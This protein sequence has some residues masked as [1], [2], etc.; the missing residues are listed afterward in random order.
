MFHQAVLDAEPHI[1]LG[2]AQG[3]VPTVTHPWH[4]RLAPLAKKSR[5]L[6]TLFDITLNVNF[7]TYL[8]AVISLLLNPLHTLL[9]IIEMI[10]SLPLGSIL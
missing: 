5:A 8:S 1:P 2:P 7:F 10:R 6:K 9:I 3:T 4:R